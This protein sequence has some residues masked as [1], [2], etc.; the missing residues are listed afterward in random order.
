MSSKRDKWI[1][2]Q[3]LVHNRTFDS[4]GH[5]VG[6][7]QS[8]VRQIVRDVERKKQQKAERDRVTRWRCYKHR[9]ETLRYW[10]TLL[11][12]IHSAEV[13]R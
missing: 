4:I 1:A 13:C 9:R 8:R 11:H 3:R 7:S 2:N 6:L 10:R 5:D 12:A